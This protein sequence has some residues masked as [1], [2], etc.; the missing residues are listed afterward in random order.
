MG[1]QAGRRA[2]K[3]E[4]EEKAARET[5]QVAVEFHASKAAENPAGLI[6]FQLNATSVTPVVE[7]MI[8]ASCDDVYHLQETMKGHVQTLAL[9]K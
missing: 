8:V 5:P 1:R 4:R 9:L 3:K 2:N 6:V 7:E